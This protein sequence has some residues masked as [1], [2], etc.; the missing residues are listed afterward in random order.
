MHGFVASKQGSPSESFPADLVAGVSD[1][2][3]EQFLEAVV[4]VTSSSIA[5]LMS[6]SSGTVAI[7]PDYIG[8]AQSYEEN[9]LF[10]QINGYKMAAATHWLAAAKVIEEQSGGCQVLDPTTA[11]AAGFSEGGS[12]SYAAAKA[13]QTV[14][15]DVKQ[16]S[17]AAP[18]LN[19][20]AS[21]A[22][23]YNELKTNPTSSGIILPILSAAIGDSFSSINPDMPNTGAGQDILSLAFQDESSFFTDAHAWLHSEQSFESL[24]TLVLTATQNDPLVLFNPNATSRIDTAIAEGT[25]EFC[26]YA[27]EGETD[28]LCEAISAQSLLAT[29]NTEPSIRLDIC[30]S[31][32]DD[33]IAEALNRPDYNNPNIFK[34]SLA[35]IEATG[36]HIFSTVVCLIGSIIPFTGGFSPAVVDTNSIQPLDDPSTCI[37]DIT[38][39][40]APSSD[41]VVTSTAPSDE[42]PLTR[43]P[44]NGSSSPS[45][46]PATPPNDTPS[47]TYGVTDTPTGTPTSATASGFSVCV[48]SIMS[49]ASVVLSWLLSL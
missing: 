39:S 17:M 16:V 11:T 32:D 3:P 24:I 8:Y 36:G 31:L 49:V 7:A 19:L 2:P 12:A 43:A 29:V 4:G 10:L 18:L 26:D 9:R 44:T 23:G 27:V 35:G 1:V 42:L 34:F 38:T 22:W 41:P 14:G 46:S 6:A 5:A 37:R 28:L 25:F 47:P 48:L 21:F 40:P 15:A 33:V 20:P 45:A 30:H 13:L